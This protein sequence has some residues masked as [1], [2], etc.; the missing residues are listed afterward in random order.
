MKITWTSKVLI[1]HLADL[2]VETLSFTDLFVYVITVK[3]Q[4][5]RRRC[6]NRRNVSRKISHYARMDG[7]AAV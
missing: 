4:R 7:A 2:A 6:V 1:S 3:S 5:R